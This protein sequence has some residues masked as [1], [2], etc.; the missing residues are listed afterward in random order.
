MVC[1]KI[2]MNNDRKLHFRKV[3]CVEGSGFFN[4]VVAVKEKFKSSMAADERL[5]ILWERERK[6]FFSAC[7]HG[8]SLC[9]LSVHKLHIIAYVVNLAASFYFIIFCQ[10]LIKLY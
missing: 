10:I 5:R 7:A 8:S 2:L 1:K 4:E 6:I 9:T 3:I